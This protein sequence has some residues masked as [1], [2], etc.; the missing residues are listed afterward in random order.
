MQFVVRRMEP[1]DAGDLALA[2]FEGWHDAHAAFMPD[3][4][5]ALRGLD[6]FQAAAPGLSPPV[7]VAV[8]EGRVVGFAQVSGHMLEKLFL[9]RKVRGTGVAQALLNA[10][11]DRI[12]AGG[13]DTGELDYVRGNARAARFYEKMG[14]DFV[15][16]ATED[17]DVPDGSTV[18]LHSIIC[19]KAL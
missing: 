15:R 17:M 18:P 7:D 6:A 2:W 5:L 13:F 10:A 19:R 1:D 8:V 11:E 14:W 16:E 3:A 4:L 12:R 9:A